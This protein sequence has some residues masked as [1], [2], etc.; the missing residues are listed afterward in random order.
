MTDVN[1]L[2][3]YMVQSAAEKGDGKIWTIDAVNA[4]SKDNEV[5]VTL[6]MAE[7]FYNGDY[8]LRCS[9]IRDQSQDANEMDAAAEFSITKGVDAKNAA[10]KETVQSYWWIGL[11]L[12]VILIGMI[13]IFAV[14]KRKVEVVSIDPDEL[15]KAD[16]RKIRLTITDRAGMIKDVEWNVEGSLFVGRSNICNIYFDDDRLSK[17]HF[18]VEVNK[19][20]CYIEDLESTN[21]TF[22]N[23]VKITGRRMLLDGDVI[24]AGREKM[25]FHLP[26]QEQAE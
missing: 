20:G 19:M 16:S 14:R 25:V 10:V 15:K 5:T 13:L 18:V 26:K 6:T 23:G 3:N 12:L 21:G 9:N 17:Q 2:S 24:T 8:I 4:V 11:V 1:E 7:D 22:V